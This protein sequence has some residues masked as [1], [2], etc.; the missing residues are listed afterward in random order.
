MDNIGTDTAGFL[1]DYL[2]KDSPAI[3]LVVGKFPD[4]LLPQPVEDVTMHVVD[5]L[6]DAEELS[7]QLQ[8][9]AG[10]SAHES[11]LLNKMHVS[12]M[13]HLDADVA[14]CQETLG[15][16]VRGF[17]HRVLVHIRVD[18]KHTGPSDEVLFAL[19]FRRLVVIPD[20]QNS[21]SRVRWFEYRLSQYK[22]SPDWLNSRFWANPERFALADD[23]DSYCESTDDDDEYDEEE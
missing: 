5:T 10:Q 19:G 3:W 6:G 14:Q 17:S 20:A 2:V 8:A 13:L 12:L 15:R 16:A 1:R 9:Q 21:A 22:N 11:S 7:A 18:H 23:P 4:E